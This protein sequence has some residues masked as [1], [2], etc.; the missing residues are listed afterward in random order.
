MSSDQP[1]GTPKFSVSSES[2]K[3]CGAVCRLLLAKEIPGLL[4]SRQVTN[5]NFP[6]TVRFE[7]FTSLFARTGKTFSAHSANWKSAKSNSNSRPRDLGLHLFPR[8]RR[9]SAGD[10]NLRTGRA[11]LKNASCEDILIRF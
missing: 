7:C 8:S 4:C 10:H 5:Q 3:A 2:M 9:P 6:I 1:N 11:N